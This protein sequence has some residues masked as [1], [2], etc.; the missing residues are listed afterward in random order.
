[1]ILELVAEAVQ[2]GARQYKA[3]EELGV[4][5]RTLQRWASPDASTEDRR[6]LADRPEPLHKLTGEEKALI[7]E[8]VHSPEFASMPL[9]IPE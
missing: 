2:S 3:C 8:T 4:T 6:P 9:S 5:P 1:M 7:L